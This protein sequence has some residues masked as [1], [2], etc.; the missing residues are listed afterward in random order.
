MARGGKVWFNGE[1]L[2]VRDAK[3]SLFTHA[4]HY[5][6]G[7][8]EGVRAYKQG[9]GGGAVFRLKEHIDRLFDSAKILGLEIP[10]TPEEICKACL[11]VTKVN[12]F[13]ECYI[14]PIAFIGD[15]PVG[16]DPGETPP[17]SVAVLN[18]EWG[19]YLGDKGVNQ[20][21][22][23]MTSTFIRPHVNSSMTKGKLT[24]AYITGVLAKREAVRLGHD[25]ALLLDP[26]GYLAEGTGENIFI[27]KDGKVKT[28]PVTCILN[29][30]T[31][32]TVLDLL[33][34]KGISVTEM[35][36]SK[37]EMWTADEVFLTGT[38]AEITPVREIDDRLIGRGDAAGKPGPISLKVLQE[39]NAM[40]RGDFPEYAK[41]WLTAL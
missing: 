37:D 32:N 6:M 13:E 16:V 4:L 3:I 23:L 35:R 7:A 10:Y 31:R 2:E 39:Y 27:V 22:K 34:N 41:G 11:D 18:W 26:D 1:I 19:R 29:G 33:K 30:I 8:F 40:V 21:V 24:G 38:A 25:E 20:G 36:F 14:R 15:G 9:K 5:G 17:I 28:T 12:G